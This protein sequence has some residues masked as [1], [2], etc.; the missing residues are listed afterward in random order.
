MVNCFAEQSAINEK[1]PVNVVGA[2]GIRAWTEVGTGPIRAMTD[3]AGELFVVSGAALYRVDSLGNSFN[4]GALPALG[5]V[6][7]V[8][9]RSDL[10]IVVS[11]TGYR[12]DGST[13]A[14]ITD[15]DFPTPK[16]ADFT[17]GYMLVVERG[18]DRFWASEINDSSTWDGLQ[19]ATAES[20]PDEL[21]GI[22][23][24]HRQIVLA[25]EKTVEIWWNSGASGFPFERIPNGAL[26]VGCSAGRSLAKADNGVFWLD[27]ERIVRRLVDLTPTRISQHG[28]EEAINGYS[29]ISDAQGF[30]FTELGHIFY[31]LDFPTEGRTWVYDA[32]TQ[33]WHERASNGQTGWRVDKYARVYGRHF[34][35]DRSTARIGILEAGTNSEWGDPLTSTWTYKAIFDDGRRIDHSRLEIIARRGQGGTT[36]PKVTLEKSD[37]GGL[38]WETLP[39]RNLGAIG[40]YKARA[41]WFQLGS[42]FDRSYRA[43]ISDDLPRLIE[44]TQYDAQAGVF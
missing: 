16:D 36:A 44:A 35:T 33:E 11:N 4:V 24:D 20:A 38:T 13:L 40:N 32:T 9:G 26:E 29:V 14:E 25:G 2:P 8:P 22:L 17:D 37:D 43:S 31:V 19:F 27:D 28:V 42:S 18:T 34:V 15:A 23:V 6:L 30:T 3:F 1:S 7:M 41:R 39:T 12:F 5:T 10:L 21:N